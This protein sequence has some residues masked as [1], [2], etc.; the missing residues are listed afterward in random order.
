[1][2]GPERMAA[3]G[4]RDFILRGPIV[5]GLL[6]LGLPTLVVITVQTLV[7]VAEAYFVSFLGTE[8]LAGVAVVFRPGRRLGD[9]TRDRR[10]A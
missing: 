10:Q 4:P 1:M 7:G 3:P 5:S 2:A 6:K 8:A 9:R